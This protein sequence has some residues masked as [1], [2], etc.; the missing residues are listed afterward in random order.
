MYVFGLA[1]NT[2]LHNKILQLSPMPTTLAGLVEKAREFNKNWC[3]FAGPTCGFQCSRNNARIQEV[4]REESE[5]NATMQHCTSFGHGRGCGRR[6]GKLSPQQCK[7]RMKNNL[8]LYC[9]KP[10]HHTIDC[11]ELPNYRP[12]NTR[13]SNQQSGP[14]VCQIDTILEEGMEKLS[15]E[16]ESRV[17]VVSANYFEP[18]VKIN[19]DDQPSFMDTL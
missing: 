8:C 19:I 3:T 7:Y 18:L 11:T 9:G 17:N 16:D 5:I 6:R 2:A 13:F 4:S 12:G 14:S 1:L 10:R 15:L